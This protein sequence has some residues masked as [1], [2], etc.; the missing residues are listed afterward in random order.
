MPSG[1]FELQPLGPAYLPLP[2]GDG[3]L[4][5]SARLPKELVEPAQRGLGAR[6]LRPGRWRLRGERGAF[7]AFAHE[8]PR[9]GCLLQAFDGVVAP[10]PRPRPMGVLNLTPDSFSDGARF[11][12][13][14]G[15][16]DTGA[17]VAEAEAMLAAGAAWLDVGGESTRPG[18]AEVPVEEEA[19][20]VGP[21]LEALADAGLIGRVSLDTRKAPVAQLGVECGVQFLNDVSGGR[22]DPRL[23][24]VAAEAGVR[25]VLMH[26]RG[27]PGTMGAHARYDDVV[28]D[29][30]AEWRTTRREAIARGVDPGRLWFDPGIGFAKQAGHNL[31]LLRRL[32]EFRALGAPIL[33]GASRKAF[34]GVATGIQVSRDRSAA[35]LAAATAG[36]LGGAELLRVHEV[37]AT[38]EALDVSAALL[39]G[40]PSP[41]GEATP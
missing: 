5:L 34:L 31:A 8:D 33:V 2:G 41:S 21:A 1:E 10:P 18:S 6:E 39:C 4:E 38:R 17:V 14:D 36:A 28:E 24:D 15:R 12:G 23:L 20:R 22:H 26:M 13:A 9:A 3:P 7:E 27:E 35:S 40:E 29:V 25:L 11:C 19:R 32:A 37:A 30:A 16:I